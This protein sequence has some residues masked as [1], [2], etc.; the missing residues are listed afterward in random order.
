MAFYA[1]RRVAQC[2]IGSV[3]GMGNHT[4]TASE[5][6][7]GSLPKALVV[8]LAWHKMEEVLSVKKKVIREFK[9]MTA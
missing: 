3:C 5:C 8:A 6:T 1:S 9:V 2:E 7:L 4:G